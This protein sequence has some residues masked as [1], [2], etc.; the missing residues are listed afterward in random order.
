MNIGFIPNSNKDNNYYGYLQVE[1]QD[2]SS[3]DQ[4]SSETRTLFKL[5]SLGTSL[6]VSDDINFSFGMSD[7]QIN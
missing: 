3:V 1:K 7:D 4:I 2:D 6:S 5:D